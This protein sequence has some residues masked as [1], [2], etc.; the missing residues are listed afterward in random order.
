MTICKFGISKCTDCGACKTNKSPYEILDA[1][2]SDMSDLTGKLNK[3]TG[4]YKM[5][6][7]VHCRECE[8]KLSVRCPI[9][10]FGLIYNPNGYCHYGVFAKE[11]C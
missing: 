11:G 7:T 8:Y 9:K 10:Y 6:E 2:A 5:V 3:L 4:Q 1:I